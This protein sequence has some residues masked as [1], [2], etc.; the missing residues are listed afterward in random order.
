MS[1]K[2]RGLGGAPWSNPRQM[3]IHLSDK[4]LNDGERG[5]IITGN[6]QVVR[7]LS[8]K[9]S[10][11]IFEF[12]IDPNYLKTILL[13]WDRMETFDGET[14]GSIYSFGDIKF[15]EDEGFLTRSKIQTSGTWRND[16]RSQ[17]A[18]TELL[19]R[20]EIR[21]PG[22]WTIGANGFGNSL[23]KSELNENDGLLVDL[24]GKIPVPDGSAPLEDILEFKQ[25]RKSELISL[26][27]AIDSIYIKIIES[28]S[29]IVKCSEIDNL[30]ASLSDYVKSIREAKFKKT[31]A[32]MAANL[33]FNPLGAGLTFGAGIYAGLPTASALI[34]AGAASLSLNIGPALKGSKPTANPFQYVRSY[35]EQIF[36]T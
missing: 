22:R 11:V 23:S 12:K 17:H 2:L 36:W 35:H 27:H 25:K 5:I 31:L 32:N 26:R 14:P 28:P 33:S 34:G 3:R 4:P 29:R 8:R 24:F 19:R 16:L 6:T 1:P 9:I 18:R 30:D 21:D 10:G 20:L 7:E 15:L 13:F